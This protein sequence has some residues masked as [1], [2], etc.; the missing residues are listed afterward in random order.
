MIRKTVLTAIGAILAIGAL[1]SPALAGHCPKDAKKIDA[2][3]SKLD[4]SKMMMAKDMS[5]KG[6]ALHKAG[7]H[8]ES[9]K[10]LHETMESLGI[11]H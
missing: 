2:A 3:M 6:L 7:K 9:L 1:S 10:V 11:K 5:S 8:A 4:K